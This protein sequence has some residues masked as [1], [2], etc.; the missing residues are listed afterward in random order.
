MRFKTDGFKG[1]AVEYSPFVTGRLACASAANFGIVGNGRLWI[2][3]TD[4]GVDR[5]Y[6]KRKAFQGLLSI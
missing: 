1:Y 4:K 6:I 2:L 3:Q 5:M